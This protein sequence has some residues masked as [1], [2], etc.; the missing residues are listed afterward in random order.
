MSTYLS[1]PQ[2]DL[3]TIIT[4][5]W[6]AE[7]RQQ[8]FDHE[9]TEHCIDYYGRAMSVRNWSP[10]HNLPVEEMRQLG[11][12]LSPETA[13]LVEGFLGIEEYVSDY[14][15]VGL[16]IN[17]HNRTR[18]NLQLQW[19]AEE[20]RHGL[21]WEAVLK[22]SGARTE[23]QLSV[24]LAKVQN[25]RWNGLQHPGLQS[26]IGA[27]AY[28]MFQERT[29][30][31]HYQKLRL[32]IRQEYGLPSTV[33][34]AEQERGCEVGASEACRLVAL[35]EIT[36]HGLFLRIVQ[37]AIKYFPSQTFDVLTTITNGFEMPA[38]RLIP[39]AR[40][41]L[42]AVLRTKFYT[43]EIHHQE[44]HIPVLKALGLENHSAFERAA[45]TASELPTEVS[46]ESITL[47]RTG[48]WVVEKQPTISS[49]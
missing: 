19:G 40:A 36:H 12:R 30:H 27:A 24:Y 23:Q 34:P 48:E 22:H 15:E 21:A 6:T 28:A 2:R 14:V 42:R 41:Y 9:V 26:P 47:Q 44:I 1:S 25:T 39:N 5:P 18:R 33:T 4:G 49:C 29:T 35:D 17:R 43:P 13:D 31:F 16:A 10:W 7:A 8:A 11:S 32:R 20:A 37:S 45:H 38:I 46:P 3:P